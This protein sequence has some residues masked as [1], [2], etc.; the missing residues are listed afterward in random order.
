[1]NR[2][3]SIFIFSDTAGSKANGIPLMAV[4]LAGVGGIIFTVFFIAICIT[5]RFRRK[6]RQNRK[7]SLQQQDSQTRN[8][9]EMAVNDSN[10][11]AYQLLT[12]NSQGSYYSLS[13]PAGHATMMQSM[14]SFT[15]KV[16]S[17]G[18]YGDH[19]SD[20]STYKKFLQLE[21]TMD[22]EHIRCPSPYNPG[23]IIEH[24]Q[25]PPVATSEIGWN[26]QVPDETTV[27][28]LAENLSKLQQYTHFKSSKIIPPPTVESPNVGMTMD[29][30]YDSS[31]PIYP[32]TKFR[33][34]SPEV[35]Y[36]WNA[37]DKARVPPIKSMTF[38]NQ[39]A[40]VAPDL[41][42]EIEAT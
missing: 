1:M 17:E 40:D 16:P 28:S 42:R 41:T 26:F 3:D 35:K 10:N 31:T 6:K 19:L 32:A 27:S 15:S 2:Q 13:R 25:P 38:K 34:K 30:R 9:L 14:G 7:T 33:I 8:A 39:D 23:F 5:C 18:D 21:Q 29:F 4:I 37:E 24:H 36:G 11:T 12:K 20:T 22:E